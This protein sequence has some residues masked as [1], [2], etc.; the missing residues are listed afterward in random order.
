MDFIE[1][2]PGSDR[3]STILVIVNRLMKQVIFVPTYD[4]VDAPGV[5]WLFLS[6]VFSKHGILAHV[7]SDQG[8]E[9]VSH[10][11]C[12]LGKL[13]QMCLH[14]TSGYHLE[15]DGQTEWANQVLEQYLRIYTN[16]QQDNWTEFLPLAEF[17][18]NNATNATTG[19]SPFFTNKGY[20]LEITV[21]LQAASTSTEVEQ[22]MTNL[23]EL[24]DALKENI[25]K[26]QEHY[27][28]NADRNRVEALDM[29]LDDLVY[30]KARYFQMSRPSKK[31]SEKNLGP[32]EIIGRPG[33]HSFTI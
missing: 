21:D 7:T 8:S 2:L 1:Q 19:V 29:K 26:A 28:K 4:M 17:A 20:H 14:F 27:Q 13:L 25:V 6:H 30:V 16:Y 9:F 3:F 12:S 5:A 24:Q 10:F 31:L 32:F 23:L 22:F 33:S 18:Y 11:F 15:G